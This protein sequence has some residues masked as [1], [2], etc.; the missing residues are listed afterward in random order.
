METQESGTEIE[1]ETET[2]KNGNETEENETEKTETEDG[3]SNASTFTTNEWII[4]TTLVSVGIF[5][6]LKLSL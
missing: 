6:L 4:R 1:T 5:R 3:A 2:E